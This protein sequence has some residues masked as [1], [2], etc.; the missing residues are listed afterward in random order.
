MV[1][2]DDAGLEVPPRIAPIQV[3]IVP[4]WR[5]AAD[6][7]TI[8]PAVERIVE[9]LKPVAR[10]KVDWRDDRT[11]GFKFND[12]ELKGVPIRLEVG[13][14]DVANNQVIAVR[15][16]TRDKAAIQIAD[17]ANEIPALLDAIQAD[18]FTAAKA[19]AAENTAIVD[20]YATP[21]ELVA[22]NA[23]WNLPIGAAILSAKRR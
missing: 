23:G 17:I 13:P 11:A 21:V 4:I 3:V 5:K 8:E 14:R 15:R 20:D 18:L 7:A 2:G 12:W 10:V 6:L 1:H 22:E 9:L 16:D 19:M